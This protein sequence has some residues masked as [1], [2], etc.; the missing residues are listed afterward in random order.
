MPAGNVG[1]QCQQALPA[2]LMGIKSIKYGCMPFFTPIMGARG[3]TSRIFASYAHE[4]PYFEHFK[5]KKMKKVAFI[6]TRD[7]SL[8]TGRV[9]EG[10]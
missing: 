9:L 3:H 5:G 10:K 8:A 7:G 4:L 6:P 1:R 2:V